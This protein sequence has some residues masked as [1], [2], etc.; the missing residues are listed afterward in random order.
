MSE[1]RA[2]IHLDLLTVHS[3]LRQLLV[4]L[5]VGVVITATMPD[6]SGALP[7]AAVFASVASSYPFAIGDKA[8]LSTIWGTLPVGRDAVVRGRSVACPSSASSCS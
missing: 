1:I 8:D 6:P 4:Q 3:Y 2:V 7:V 5:A